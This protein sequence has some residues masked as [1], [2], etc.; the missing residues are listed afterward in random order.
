VDGDTTTA[1]AVGYTGPPGPSTTLTEQWNS[2]AWKVVKSPNP[3]SGF[4]A[5]NGVAQIGK[6]GE[7][8]GHFWAVGFYSSGG[9]T[10]NTLIL[11]C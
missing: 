9:V 2:S 11:K 10:Y 3:G 5:L 6:K 4:N 1:F 7:T 8:G